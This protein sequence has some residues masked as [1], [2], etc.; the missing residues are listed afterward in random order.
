LEFYK[1]I[2]PFIMSVDTLENKKLQFDPL[3]MSIHPNGTSLTHEESVAMWLNLS[4]ISE[5]T[6][7]VLYS[8]LVA[9]AMTRM[10]DTLQ[11]TDDVTMRI[12][13]LMRVFYFDK[14]TLEQLPTLLKDE[15][16]LPQEKIA[17]TMNFIR[18]E[19]LTLKAQNISQE[20]VEEEVSQIKTATLILLGALAQYP[21]IND[22]VLTSNRLQVRNEKELV[23][24][25]V[26]NW[27]RAYRDAVG[28][29]NHTAIERGQFLFHSENTKKLASAERDRLAVVLKSL[30][31]NELLTIDV[32]KQEIV[33]PRVITAQVAPVQN[34]LASIAPAK[35]TPLHP[36]QSSP[37][38]PKQSTPPLPLAKPTQNPIASPSISSG[39]PA[40][41]APVRPI[42]T[43]MPVAP[44][45][46]PVQKPPM[47]P[48]TPTLNTPTPPPV[49]RI[50]PM[51]TFNFSR[52]S[53]PTP[54]HALPAS[55]ARMM[56]Q[57][58][59]S[60]S[61]SQNRVAPVSQSNTLSQK[62]PIATPMQTA[63]KDPFH[64]SSG[65]VLPA[66]KQGGLPK[67]PL[68]TQKKEVWKIA[69]E[70]EDSVDA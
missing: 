15:V 52:S 9:D 61:P 59:L 58:P 60:S 24:G 14:V 40:M 12:A 41:T 11:L 64:F 67:S 33:F 46:N 36:L 66:E 5:E 8:S 70:L 56:P 29:R 65:Q 44:L 49:K 37:L 57:Q 39:A 43:P 68:S 21:H 48:S 18:T 3:L 50:T 63:I 55:P 25:S 30:D 10:H 6:Y 28:V 20:T 31:D 1:F 34:P 13:A 23:R 17:V 45:V 16:G 69:S 26:R 51:S 54:A 22:Q 53:A 19:I 38:L 62:S 7:Q 35:N 27:L 4:T 42:A 47:P 32:E 2:S